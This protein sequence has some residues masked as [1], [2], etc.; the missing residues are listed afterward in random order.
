MAAMSS[1]SPSRTI[2]FVAEL[3]LQLKSRNVDIDRLAG[4]RTR[5]QGTNLQ[6]KEATQQMARELAQHMQSW[7]PTMAAP[8]PSRQQR[9]LDL[10]AEIAKLKGA[11]GDDGSTPTTGPT[12][13]GPTP[14]ASTP[15]APIVQSL[16]KRPQS[17]PTFDPSSL[18]VMLGTTNSWLTSNPIPTLTEAAYKKWL[19]DLQLPQPKLDTLNPNLNKASERWQNQHGTAGATIS[20]VI[21][22]MGMGMDPI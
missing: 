5:Q 22:A 8:D 4:Y 21:V 2:V 9:I 10:E 3:V 18:L 1:S 19:K 6:Q 13:V 20:C 11:Q 17:S 14:S 7:L 15:S 16:Q 12:G